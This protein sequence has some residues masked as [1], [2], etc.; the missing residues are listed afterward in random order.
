VTEHGECRPDDDGEEENRRGCHR[1]AP[2][3][4][5]SG[6]PPEIRR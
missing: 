1:P 5:G 4:D 6:S 2:G 3:V